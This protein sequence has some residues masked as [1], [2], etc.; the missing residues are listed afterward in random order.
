MSLNRCTLL[1][2]YSVENIDSLF[3]GEKSGQDESKSNSLIPL[4]V[5]SVEHIL[6]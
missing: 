5:L 1:L 4:M 2:E 6:I 3:S